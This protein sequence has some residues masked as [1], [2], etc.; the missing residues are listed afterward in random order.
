MHEITE[1]ECKEG[2]AEQLLNNKLKACGCDDNKR[3]DCTLTCDCVKH[4]ATS[5]TAQLSCEL[6]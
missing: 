2:M 1:S 6:S 4:D 3:T 5:E